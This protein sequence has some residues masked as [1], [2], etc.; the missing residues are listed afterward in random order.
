MLYFMFIKFSV[1]LG[2]IFRPHVIFSVKVN[3]YI[4][5]YENV[6]FKMN[7]QLEIS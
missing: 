7:F 4:T 3:E 2:M 6:H 1:H 5:F